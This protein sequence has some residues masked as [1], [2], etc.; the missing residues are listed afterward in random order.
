MVS[1]VTQ[2][3][4]SPDID[5]VFYVIPCKEFSIAGIVLAQLYVRAPVENGSNTVTDM[6]KL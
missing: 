3:W 6:N 2:V 1:V 4:I 5:Q